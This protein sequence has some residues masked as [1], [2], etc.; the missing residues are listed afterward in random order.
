M[1]HKWNGGNVELYCGGNNHGLNDHAVKHPYL[2]G[3]GHQ[4]IFYKTPQIFTL[5]SSYLS[6]FD[7]FL[8]CLVFFVCCLLCLSLY[9]F[10]HRRKL[11]PSTSHEF[12][13]NCRI[14]VEEGFRQKRRQRS[15]LLLGGQNLF[16][17]LQCYIF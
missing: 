11:S 15:S 7:V 12:L 17:S 3:L 1:C 6:F 13:K 10:S 2:G 14:S 4:L 16:N 8:G 9:F 5:H